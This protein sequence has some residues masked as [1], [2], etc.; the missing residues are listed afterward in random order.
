MELNLITG[1][2]P[3]DKNFKNELQS[4][5]AITDVSFRDDFDFNSSLN[6]PEEIES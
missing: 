5:E 3:R 4:Y 6:C 2:S 1:L